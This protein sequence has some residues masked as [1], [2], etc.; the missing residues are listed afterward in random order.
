MDAL[1]SDLRAGVLTLT[2]H[3]PERANALTLNLITTLRAALKQAEHDSQVRVVVITGAG[4]AFSA[5]HDVHEMQAAAGNVSYRE[6]LQATYNPLILHL[7]T[8]PKPTLAAVPGT[9]AGAGLGI[10]LACDLRIASP[11]A[12]FVVGFRRLGLVP[13][14]G[15]SLLLPALIGM[16]RALEFYLTNEAIDAETAYRWGLVNRI[17]STDLMSTVQAL[18]EQL[19]A[20]PL[21]VFG[22]ARHAF[23]QAVIPH[24]ER[25]LALE[26]DLQ[27]QAGRSQ[28]H[29]RA[30]EAFLR[31]RS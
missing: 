2:F 16:G 15:V 4:H 23:H 3:R 7:C 9:C 8:L 27:E 5:G 6:H 11:Q 1:L 25:I 31:K 18:A 12:R 30:V 19:A 14:S 24:L 17:V 21:E 26:A 20:G 10:A 13:D 29:R 22:K 28:E